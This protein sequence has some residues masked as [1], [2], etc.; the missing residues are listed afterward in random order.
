MSLTERLA[1][2]EAAPTGPRVG[3]FFD[4]DGTLIDGYSALAMTQARLRGREVGPVEVIRTV[5]AGVNG[6]A[7]RS[8]FADFMKVGVRPFR[9]RTVE[10]LER[11]GRRL[12]KTALGGSLHP[13]AW[14]IVAAHRRQGHT[15]VIASSALPF[16]VEGL[17]AELEVDHV[18]CTRL[19]AVDGRLTGEIDGDVLW[20]EG[21]AKAVRALARR[22]RISLE[23]SFA[24]ANGTEDIEFLSLVAHPCAVNPAGGLERVARPRGWPIERFTGRARGGVTDAARTVAAYGGLAASF[25]VGLG[26]G[27]LNRSRREAVNL[28]ATMGSDIALSIAG[29]E[30]DVAGEAN[31]WSQ[32]PAVFVF[33]HQSWLD[34]LIIMK[35]LR[36]DI[37]G[38]AKKEVASQPGFGQFA[39]L[40]NMTFVDRT[41]G[42]DPKTALAPAVQRLR[43]GYSIV[44]SPEGTRSTTPRLG[45][46]KKGAFHMAMQGG[47]PIV[48]IV[49]RD[50]G[51][52][53]W[54]GSTIIRPGKV[55]V[56]VH[57]P[58]PTD[59]WTAEG[60][61]ERIAEVR[62]LFQDTLDHWER[63][64]EQIARA[65]GR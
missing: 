20:G 10:E 37:T 48:P 18:L 41:S 17:A 24:Y 49:I 4:F 36:G 12:A 34:G 30:V 35:L 45:P 58:I 56:I 64:R 23:R 62:A 63:A 9:G 15:V 19:E 2:I 21:K 11:F 13:E 22:E 65:G 6:A 29:V 16:Q 8:D 7:G 50:A 44:I 42:A 31:L 60:L 28:S 33:N 46:F 43:E 61:D 47:V 14:A 32:R 38:V 54:R 55:P 52:R 25:G 59:A 51:Q 40:A 53:L 3:A 5:L 27:L 57:P 26:I 1:A 39:K